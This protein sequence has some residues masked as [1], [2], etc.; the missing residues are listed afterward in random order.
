VTTPAIAYKKELNI[1]SELM[2]MT[3][4]ESRNLPGKLCQINETQVFVN[5][6]QMFDTDLLED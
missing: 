6:S 4:I 1:N 5:G 2:I 3:A